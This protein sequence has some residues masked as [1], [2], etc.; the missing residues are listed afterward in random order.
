MSKYTSYD[1]EF[2]G[3]VVVE[4]LKGQKTMAQIC[5]EYAVADDLV[6]HWKQ[7]FLDRAP[8]LF[9][10]KQQRSGEQEQIAD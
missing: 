10:T 9:R 1:A 8:E 6:C 2:K 5:R 3:K 4:V 7:V